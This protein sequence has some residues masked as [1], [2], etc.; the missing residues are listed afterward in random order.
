[1][2]FNTEFNISFF[3]P[4]KDLCDECKTFNVIQNPTEQEIRAKEE[5]MRRKSVGK[6][7]RDR[8]RKAHAK[9]ETVG[10]V[11]VDMQNIFSL[12]KANI[13]YFFYRSKLT[14]YNLT[15]HLDKIKMV[16]NAIWHEMICGRSGVHLAN[17][18]IRILE[19]VVDD[20]PKSKRII[21]WS[22]N[23]VP[24]NRNSIMS[25]AP[26]HFLNS[27]DW[28][29]FKIIKQKFNEPGHGT[30]QEI[31]SAHSCIERYKRHLEWIFLKLPKTW[32]FEF[33][34]LQ[35]RQLDYKNYELVSNNFQYDVVPYTKVNTKKVT[36]AEKKRNRIEGDSHFPLDLQGV[37]SYPVLSNKKKKDI[38]E[39]MT[40]IPEEDREFYK[41]MI[42][43]SATNSGKQT[44]SST[45]GKSKKKTHLKSPC[46]TSRPA[47]SRKKGVH[48]KT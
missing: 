18:L 7:E 44:L 37:N 8:D 33:K 40:K 34:V 6:A 35:M 39:I 10:A 28:K 16:Y 12:P 13:T 21:L 31:D 23:C 25:F 46:C 27:S 5:H 45:S 41:Q 36:L 1:M 26:Q 24:Q 22:D 11:T 32:K 19:S 20:N 3:K 2:I 42:S 48:Q 29:I 17:A 4:K 47:S 14:C 9:D 38:K 30:V 15:A 43:L